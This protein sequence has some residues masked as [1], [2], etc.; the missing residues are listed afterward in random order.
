MIRNALVIDQVERTGFALAT[1][2]RYA[3]ISN[4]FTA[5]GGASLSQ[6]YTALML[7]G[8]FNTSFGANR[9]K[10]LSYSFQVSRQRAADGKATTLYYA[11]LSIPLGKT[12]PASVSASMSRDGKGRLGMQSTLSGTLGVD[13]DL[14]Y[15]ATVN[16]ASGGGQDRQTAASGNV[17][18]RTSVGDLSGSV[19][20]G[21]GYTQGS[22][23]MRGG[24]VAHPG[25]IT[26]APSLS[27]TFGV[28][29]VP[30]A[31][32]ARL[33][34][35]PGVKV[36]G[37]GYAV[38]PYLTPYST[39]AVDLDPKG[40][41][42]DVELQTTSQ[43]VAPRAGAIV[44]L[45]YETKSGPSALFQARRADGTALPFGA[46]VVDEKQELIGMVGQASKFIARGL[47]DKGQLTVTLGEDAA[48]LCRI[49]YEM[50]VREKGRKADGYKLMDVNCD[51]A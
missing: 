10:N 49:D 17:Y 39:N 23:G 36:N 1:F 16:H 33:V 46:T 8:A 50:P 24:V 29:E 5:Y 26:L 43:Q 15:G 31:E 13:N 34:N 48:V 41:S 6:G 12:Q 35:A 14:S 22:V 19:G 20:V 45:K 3:G 28:V 37:S 30:D 27:E 42:T 21:S 4:M 51:P 47:Q 32:G 11:S 44:L 18:Y 25:G 9:Y 38:V 40:L 7:G 2:M